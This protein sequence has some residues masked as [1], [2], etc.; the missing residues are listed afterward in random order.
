MNR[1]VD[2][3]LLDGA[4][5]SR[6]HFSTCT[7]LARKARVSATIIKSSS[8]GF[9]S[10]PVIH[11][12]TRGILHITSIL[13]AMQTSHTPLP[14]PRYSGNAL[15]TDS[16][17][18]KA[19]AFAG[20][21]LKKHGPNPLQYPLHPCSLYTPLAAS[22]QV[23]NLLSGPSESV[24]MRCFTTSLGY[25]VIQKTCADKPPAQKLTAGAEREVCVERAW[26]KT[27]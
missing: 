17:A 2:S 24:M 15:I 27:S 21:A 10:N 8:S 25:D 4:A 3:A 20:K 7:K 16:N 6:R 22:L 18:T 13:P 1:P 14:F 26:V 12:Y 11:T 9:L 5:P 23:R 19:I